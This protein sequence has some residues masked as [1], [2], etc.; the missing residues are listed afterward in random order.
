MEMGDPEAGGRTIWNELA[1][2]QAPY[3]QGE[4]QW[5]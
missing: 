5:L 1:G 2:P 4:R 3:D